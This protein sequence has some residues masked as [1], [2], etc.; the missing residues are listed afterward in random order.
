MFYISGAI[1]WTFAWAW[2]RPDAPGWQAILA[3]FSSWLGLV[4]WELAMREDRKL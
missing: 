1:M 4:M 3:A 2:A